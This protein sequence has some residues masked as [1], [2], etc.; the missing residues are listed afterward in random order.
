MRIV[1]RREMLMKYLDILS[2]LKSFI[3]LEGQLSNVSSLL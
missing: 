1:N 2:L 3:T